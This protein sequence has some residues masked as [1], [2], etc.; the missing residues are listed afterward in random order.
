METG[1]EKHWAVA[2]GSSK[3]LCQSVDSFKN[4]LCSDSPLHH[5]LF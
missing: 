1:E 3:L 2:K 5:R 4:Y